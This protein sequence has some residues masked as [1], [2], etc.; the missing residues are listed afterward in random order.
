MPPSRLPPWPRRLPRNS[1]PCTLGLNPPAAAYYSSSSSSSQW[2]QRQA[3]DVHAREAKLHGLKSR[4]AFKLLELDRAHRLFRRGQV[5]VDLGFAPGS[6][7]QVAVQRTGGGGCVVGIDLLPAAVPR[8]VAAAFTGDFLDPRQ[9]GR[10]R[11]W[12]VGWRERRARGEAGRPARERGP[13]EG[14]REGREGGPV[15]E[16]DK[17]VAGEEEDRG[18]ENAGNRSTPPRPRRAAAAN[19]S[20]AAGPGADDQCLVDVRLHTSPCTA[21]LTTGRW[22][23]TL[24]P[25]GSQRHVRLERP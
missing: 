17:R 24:R 11:D 20:S 25:G 6:W 14:E 16:E 13:A 5:V 10:L 19:S 23:L 1:S 2:K 3:T 9:R 7:S 18:A 15:V 8:G 4:A 12:L 21:S 22:I